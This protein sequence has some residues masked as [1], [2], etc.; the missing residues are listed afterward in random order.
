MW[1]NKNQETQILLM[2]VSLNYCVTWDELII[3]SL[4]QGI[5]DLTGSLDQYNSLVPYFFQIVKMS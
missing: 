4:S 3:L 5:V 1:Y 2:A